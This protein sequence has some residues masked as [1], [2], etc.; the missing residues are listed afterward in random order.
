MSEEPTKNAKEA[1]QRMKKGEV[2]AFVRDRLKPYLRESKQ[3]VTEVERL[4]KEIE[5]L[6]VGQASQRQTVLPVPE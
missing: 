1:R 3:I 5:R 6:E 2:S 4:T